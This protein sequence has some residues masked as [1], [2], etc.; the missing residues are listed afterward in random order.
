[1][2]KFSDDTLPQHQQG[3]VQAKTAASAA[4]LRWVECYEYVSQA[5]PL[6]C[7]IIRL[8]LSSS[9]PKMFMRIILVRFVFLSSTTRHTTVLIVIAELRKLNFFSPGEEGREI[10]SLFRSRVSNLSPP[11]TYILKNQ[12]S[13]D[14]SDI[15]L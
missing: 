9:L 3:G 15:P 10:L 4:S 7:V 11:H 8:P 6:Q 12:R 1:M 5:S 14:L 2:G 13:I